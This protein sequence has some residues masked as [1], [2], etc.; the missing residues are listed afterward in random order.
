MAAAPSRPG[1]EITLAE[2]VRLRQEALRLRLPPARRAGGPLPDAYHTLYRGRGLE[3][4]ESRA[5]QPGDDFRSL[6]W[7]VT[8]RTGRLHTKIFLEEREHALLVAVDA[9]ATM[10]FGSRIAFKWV[11]AARLAAML[12][13]MAME[14]GDRAGGLVYGIGA[15]IRERAPEAGL[16]GIMPLLKLLATT[17]D[18][19]TGDTPSPPAPAFE[20]LRRIARHGAVVAV[21]SDFAAWDHTAE[22]ALAPL[23]AANDV[24]LIMVSDPLEAELPPPGRFVFQAGNDLLAV[25]TGDAALRAAHARAFAERRAAVVA[26]CRRNGARFCAVSTAQTPVEALREGLLRRRRRG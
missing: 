16:D 10:R 8:A 13:W 9:G 19:P 12:A 23:A 6:D 20:R 11:A 5:Y 4:E 24:M 17:P 1:V 7:R 3:F 26:A 14:N 2:L 21:L 15:R 22:T 18:L 25:D